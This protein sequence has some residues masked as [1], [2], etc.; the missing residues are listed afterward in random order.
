EGALRKWVLPQLSAPLL[1]IRDPVLVLAYVLAWRARVFPRNRWVIALA[2]I[3]FRSLLVSIIPLWIDSLKRIV[4][5]SGFG[6]R[7]N[8]LHLSLIFLMPAVLTRE[9][10]KKLGWWT[11]LFMVPMTLLMVAQFQGGPDSILNRTASGEGE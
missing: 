9:D 6:F 2:I 7:A 5:S 11:L 8:F 1:I 10:I 3:G 4:L